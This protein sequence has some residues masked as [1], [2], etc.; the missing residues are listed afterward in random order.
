MWPVDAYVVDSFEVEVLPGTPPGDYTLVAQ[1]FDR[2]TLAALLPSPATAPGLLA[3]PLGTIRVDRANRVFDADQLR[4]YGGER[5]A[6]NADLT[7]LGYNIDRI[8]TVP[9]ESVLLTFFWQA[10]SAPQT[11]YTLRIDLVG[12]GGDMLESQ[13]VLIGGQ[14]YPTSGWSEGEQIITLAQMR[15]PASTPSGNYHWR[16]SILDSAGQPTSAFDLRPAFRVAAPERTFD[17][18]DMQ[19][20]VDM[21]LGEF[22]TLLG[23]D[24]S[25]YQPTPGGTIDVTLYWQPRTETTTSY[26][27]FVH[28][29]DSAGKIAAQADAFPVEG[30]RPTTGWLPGEVIE[31]RYTFA[32]SGDVPEGEYQLVAGLYD[33]E[34]GTRVKTGEGGEAVPLAE[35][36]VK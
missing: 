36:E 32:L 18:P 19:N 25:T 9:G 30:E 6:L 13:D 7:L 15:V 23:F 3:A 33:P 29:L 10:Q 31:D 17:V 24:L 16:G 26:K 22:A 4:I 5:I 1:I 20:R 12:A 34:S 14:A 28:L 35:I 8:D 2:E 21:E 11:D 27:V